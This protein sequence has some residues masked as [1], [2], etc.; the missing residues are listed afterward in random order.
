MFFTW[1]EVY[2]AGEEFGYNRRVL[3]EKEDHTRQLTEMFHF[4]I[5]VGKQEA[6]DEIGAIEIDDLGDI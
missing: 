3:E 5:E 6:L 2:K 4:G 1:K